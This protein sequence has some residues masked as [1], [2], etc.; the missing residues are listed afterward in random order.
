[1]NF[2]K[3]LMMNGVV[4]CSCGGTIISNTG[5]IMIENEL[6]WFG[7]FLGNRIF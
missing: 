2:E 1:M 5:K 6:P 7:I 4:E 3:Q